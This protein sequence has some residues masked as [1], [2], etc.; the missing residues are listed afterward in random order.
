MSS[1]HRTWLNGITAPLPAATLTT[2]IAAIAQVGVLTL[3]WRPTV[4]FVASTLVVL[5]ATVGLFAQAQRRASE[6]VETPQFTAASMLTAIRGSAVVVLGGFLVAARPSG[7]SAWIPA[8]L[9]G[10]AALLD[11]A[12]GQI[13]RRTNTV[14]PFGSRVDVEVDALAL[15]VGVVVAIQYGAVPAIF[16][17]V[18]V[19]RYAF[20]GG[21][22]WRRLTSKP[23]RE[24]PPSQV[25]RVLGATM[26]C[27]VFLALAPLPERTVTRWLGFV[28]IIPFLLWFL[29]DWLVVSTRL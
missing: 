10:T 19:A 24:L 25:R 5:G 11:A 6:Q 14:T 22:V 12:D 28:S 7:S 21:I 20:L 13:A 26:L 8:L 18:G 9:F 17:L 4:P 2:I 27:V 3:V 1:R 16:M 15:L 29:R 23:T